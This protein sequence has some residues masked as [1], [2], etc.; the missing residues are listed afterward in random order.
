[1]PSVA[2]RKKRIGCGCL[3]L[4]LAFLVLGPFMAVR[5]E[6]VSSSLVGVVVFGVFVSVLVRAA[7]RA[8]RR[9]TQK[10]EPDEVPSPVPS[11]SPPPVQSEAPRAS[12]ISVE[13]ASE[14]EP[15]RLPEVSRTDTGS[16]RPE[17]VEP[18]G[19]TDSAPIL[20]SEEMIRRA[21]ERI[22]RY[23]EE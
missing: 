17:S 19:A 20:T 16:E 5:D 22:R 18:A 4:V 7:V 9:T 3:P 2:E 23:G 15:L 1:M 8:A 13:S 14:A 21:K 10:A 11:Q 12:T 6:A